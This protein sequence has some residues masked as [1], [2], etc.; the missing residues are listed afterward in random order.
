MYKNVLREGVNR[1]SIEIPKRIR[2]STVRKFN[3]PQANT[4]ISITYPE[5]GDDNLKGAFK[6]VLPQVYN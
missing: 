3:T 6:L 2:I 5:I 4:T 1:R